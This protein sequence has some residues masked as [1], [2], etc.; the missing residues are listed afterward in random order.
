[1]LRRSTATSQLQLSLAA[2]SATRSCG[3]AALHGPTR[4][5]FDN[6][7]KQLGVVAG[8]SSG[9]S[10]GEPNAPPGFPPGFNAQQMQT[11]QQLFNS[12][13]K[14]KQAQLM[15]QAMEM[16]KMMSRIPGM[17][18]MAQKNAAMLEQM[19]KM[20]GAA[21]AAAAAPASNDNSG[22]TA[23][24]SSARR[25][26]FRD[27]TTATPNKPRSGPSL[28]ELKKVNLGPEI[29]A[30]FDEL[31]TTRQ[32]KNEYRDK[33]HAA[34]SSLDELRKAHNDLA[35]RETNVRGK[36]A[37]AEQDVMLLTSENMELRD[38]SKAVKQLTH[39]NRQLKHEVDQLRSAA[40]AS[41]APGTASYAAL[42]QRH[43]ATED[44]LRSLQRK[45][46]RM[47][48]R[49]PLL[50]FSL[51]CSDVSRLCT[52]IRA[53]DHFSSSGG[54]GE[55]SAAAGGGGGSSNAKEALGEAGQEA[56]EQAFADLQ[57]IYLQR[58]QEAWTA[59]GHEHGAAARAYVA[60]V[61]RYVM[62]RVPHA[63]Y[64]AVVSFTGDVAAL[65]AV[66]TG[67]GFTVESIP[68]DGNRVHV[69]AAA[70]A[71]PWT[72]MP[73]PYGYAFALRLSA[74]GDP[75]NSSSS[76]SGTGGRAAFTVTSAHPFVSATLMHNDKRCGVQ[77]ET[78][79]AS[80]PGGQ[81]T[82][83]SETQVY[84]KC[85]IDGVPA[86]TAES[87][88]SRSAMSNKEAALEK[89]RQQRRQQY[90]DTLAKQEKAE[91]VQAQLVEAVRGQGGLTMDEEVL[92]L[93][94]EAAAARQITAGDAALVTMMR[95]LSRS[96]AST[97]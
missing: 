35:A 83:V 63:N 80:G 20:Q 14:E 71:A 67:V 22:P 28:D 97:I 89:L 12:Q 70:G 65:R 64:D 7:K 93:V 2:A 18:K 76:S 77:Y 56:A 84:A 79:R 48:R 49:D 16:Q 85:S 15:T 33:Y 90:N 78:A 25:D 32:R 87:Q 51:A 37:K 11:L 91:A 47:R 82:N 66:F 59:A 69:V 3:P 6:L 45:V 23:P 52:S 95:E 9:S 44:A 36:L 10:A 73:G 55:S 57:R 19:L 88:D 81:A 21:P 94:Q 74:A 46:D 39:T 75:P 72:D 42:K 96:A 13:P 1:M 92:R 68:G 38:S 4:A 24:P 86:F 58:L 53:D 61:R 30:L 34:Q 29:E 17:G 5:L 31:R 60:V 54:G 40:Q 27:A 26:L 41:A 50:Q 62:T 8:N 43:R